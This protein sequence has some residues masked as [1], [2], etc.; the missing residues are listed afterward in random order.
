MNTR[1]SILH[2]FV[3]IARFK[4]YATVLQSVKYVPTSLVTINSYLQDKRLLMITLKQGHL[5]SNGF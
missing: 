5:M 2:F 1:L 3:V 4:F